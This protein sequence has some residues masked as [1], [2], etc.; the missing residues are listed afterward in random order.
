MH[1]FHSRPG[2]R[3]ALIV[4]VAIGVSLMVSACATDPYVGS[5]PMTAA[6][7]A[8]ET[9]TPNSG[10][11]AALKRVAIAT[12]AAGDYA[13][14]INVLKRAHKLAPQDTMILLELGESLAAVGAYNEAREIMA[15][16][17]AAA[18]HE[19]RA[20]RGLA[21]ALLALA[22]P[23]LALG[24]YEAAIAV[25]PEAA[26]YSGLG[27][28]LD[29]LGR[30]DEA[31]TAYRAGLALDARNPALI[32]NLGL[33]LALRDRGPEAIELIAAELRN[34]RSTAKLRQN[35]ALVY[36]LAGRMRDAATVL[37]ID[38]GTRAV[39][40]N[41]AYYE[42]LRGLSA[43]QRRET[44]LGSRSIVA[45]QTSATALT[46]PRPKAPPKSE[47]ESPAP[48]TPVVTAP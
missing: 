22:E 17:L 3:R 14:A 13:S 1:L 47:K 2:P 18:P 12:R 38:L 11:A 20:L 44:V 10:A 26:S 41:L 45:S 43:Q 29:A 5:V 19:T 21:N 4:P 36:G 33:S 28:A 6:D 25:H 39:R 8:R 7:E 48:T 15:K 40:N 46:V 35:L 27:V 42:M 34:G 9:E 24:H 23:A 31:D 16:A 30:A 37:R 32:G